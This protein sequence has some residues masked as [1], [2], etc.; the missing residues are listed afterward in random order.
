MSRGKRQLNVNRNGFFSYGAKLFWQEYR[1]K[2]G[3]KVTQKQFTDILR[4]FHEEVWKAMAEELLQ[5]E[6]P[7]INNLVYIIEV[8]GQGVPKNWKQIIKKRKLVVLANMH[9]SGR[10]YKVTMKRTIKSSQAARIYKFKPIRG[11]A[12]KPYVGKRGLG[13]FIKA[14]SKDPNVPD[15]RAHIC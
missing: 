12:S 4:A 9:T 5:Y 8:I 11:K 2:T 13:T 7:H 3:R 14:R 1:K 15:F 10:M 6:M